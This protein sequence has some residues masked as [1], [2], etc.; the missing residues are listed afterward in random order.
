MTACL[1]DFDYSVIRYF[2]RRTAGGNTGWGRSE[3]K[4]SLGLLVN[5]AYTT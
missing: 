2:R 1:L 5:S 3:G 4:V